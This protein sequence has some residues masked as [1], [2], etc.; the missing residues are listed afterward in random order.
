MRSVFIDINDI[1]INDIKTEID[2]YECISFDVFDT[3]IKRN[4]VTP[5]DL[6]ELMSV[7]LNREMNVTN[8][9]E[10]RK[11]AERIAC[12]RNIHSTIEEIYDIVIEKIPQL[13]KTDIINLEEKYELNY[14][15]A[16]H[17]I[18]DVFKYAKLKK[19][20]IIAVSDM[21]LSKNIINNILKNCGYYVDE[22]YVS[23][24]EKKNKGDGS[25]FE[26]VLKR[27][28]IKNSEIIHIG[29]S[30][31]SDYL[32]AKKCGIKS[33][34]IDRCVNQYNTVRFEK[35]IE[36]KVKYGVH[37]SIINNNLS[38]N[39]NFYE[40]FGFSIIG[41]ALF[42][43]CKWIEEKCV[44]NNIHKLFFFSRDGFLIKQAF[45]CIK[46]SNIETKYIYVSR[47]SLRIPYNV[48]HC[49]VDEIIKMLPPTCKINVKVLINYLG[50]NIDE[51]KN[52]MAKYDLDEYDDIIYD[53]IRDKYYDFLRDILPFYVKNGKEELKNA[54]SYLKQE[55]I[56]GRVGVVD[57]GWH[58]TMQFC[59]ENVLSEAGVETDIYGL[60]FGCC[61]GG[62]FVNKSYSYIEE[63]N[64]NHNI[65][66]CGAFIGLIE[67]FFLEQTG[68]T[69]KYACD[70]NCVYYPIKE[71]Y[72]FEKESIEYSA[73][74]EI[75]S[76]A[77]K[78]IKII[79]KLVDNND[80]V[81]SGRDAYLPIYSFGIHPYM[82]DVDRFA[83]FRYFSEGV[84]PLVGYKGF[85]YYLLHPTK[86]KIDLFN[87]KWKAGFLK[88]I[89]KINAPYGYIY[90]KLKKGI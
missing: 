34:K 13:N 50:L 51:V 78:F 49:T 67:S 38:L 56:A 46:S 57:I 3:L 81:L 59:M 25:L 69:L 9:S 27:E 4:V 55:G 53:E 74:S 29:D 7:E 5:S 60:Y 20:R 70:D 45:E 28:S 86:L 61:E 90:N 40:K 85:I 62:A 68:T 83:N 64:G 58:N 17:F 54:V 73:Y 88:K 37:K 71:K 82:T 47:R 76:G 41:P 77:L 42:S 33:I 36:D 84:Y 52:I 10:I 80:L 65:K 23:C 63:P 32:G 19:K 11:Q 44:N 43:F 48:S 72:E 12:R 87:A 2:A 24:E 30:F 75:H 22:I 6:F 66:S 8:F 31:K 18:L 16:N 39:K 89:L 35:K 1:K 15:Q 14:C 26:E 21:Y 79:N